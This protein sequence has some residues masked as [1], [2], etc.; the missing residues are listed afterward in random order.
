MPTTQIATERIERTEEADL[1]RRA[2]RRDP[3]AIRHI[4]KSHNQR[5]YRLARAVVRSNADAEEVLQD[6]YLRAFEHL[7]RFRGES[8]LS[9]WLC[10][11]TLNEALTR[12]RRQRRQKRAVASA[13]SAAEAQIIPFPINQP[14]DDPE[15]TMAQ[16][17]LIQLVEQAT[18]QETGRVA[19]ALVDD[20]RKDADITLN[21]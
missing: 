11:I 18:S 4:I 9:T 17:Q 1:V 15:R 14:G 10:R 19:T 8:S 2:A 6:A 3:D 12:L 5:L 13:G 21:L 7:D 16:R 20:L